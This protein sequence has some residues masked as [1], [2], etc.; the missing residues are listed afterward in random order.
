VL[1]PVEKWLG[2]QD[3]ALHMKILQVDPT[4]DLHDR[5]PHET[6]RRK[7]NAEFTVET[8]NET[9]DIALILSKRSFLK[10][11]FSLDPVCE[12]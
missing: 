10:I 11:P 12:V 6:E 5:M 7:G 1:R 9:L 2:D 8:Y 3:E 4:F